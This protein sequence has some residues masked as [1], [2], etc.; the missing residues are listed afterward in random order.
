[1]GSECCDVKKSKTEAALK[2]SDVE[3]LTAVEKQLIIFERR[4]MTD[5]NAQGKKLVYSLSDL[6]TRFNR[7]PVIREELSIYPH[8]TGL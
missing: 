8:I 2:K 7:L 3:S 1:M 6:K 5:L 4:N